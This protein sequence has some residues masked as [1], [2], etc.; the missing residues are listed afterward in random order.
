[1]EVEGHFE[2]PPSQIEETHE[3]PNTQVFQL[4]LQ[5]WEI[6]QG[7]HPMQE[8]PSSQEEPLAWF[9]EYF[10]KLHATMERMEQRHKQQAKYLE[11]IK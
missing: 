10:G 9:L 2:N 6:M 4:Q 1:M 8:G 5:E 11:Q 7:D 3:E